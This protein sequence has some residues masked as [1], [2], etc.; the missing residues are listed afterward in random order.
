MPKNKKT[1]KTSSNK[2]LST[3]QKKSLKKEETIVK[4][5]ITEN[6]ESEKKFKRTKLTQKANLYFNVNVFRSWLIKYYKQNEFYIPSPKVKKGEEAPKKS[7]NIIP[8]L[9]G[10]HIALA[11]VSQVLCDHILKKSISQL[12]PE[13]SGLYNICRA[14]I[15]LAVQLN[16]DLKHLFIRAMEFYD[17]NMLYTDQFCLSYSQVMKYIE[18]TMG[19]NVIMLDTKAYNLLA[20]LLLK[21]NM[22]LS[23]TIYHILITSKKRSLGFNTIT[24]AINILCTG[25]LKHDLLLKLQ[26]TQKLFINL[27]NDDSLN[28]E[29]SKDADNDNNNNNDDNDDDD[30]DNSEIDDEI[31]NDNDSDDDNDDNDDD[32]DDNDNDNDDDDDDDGYV[33][34]VDN[35]EEEEEESVVVTKSKKSKKK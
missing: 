15:A 1:K 6:L 27:K 19:K 2:N 3:K 7:S 22:E 9:N 10:V 29:N 18:E 11:A 14:P 34:D 13:P 26:D 12:D 31:D 23:S 5:S 17:W 21:F 4:D 25:S 33:E 35:E 8:K 16:S 20:Y 24:G 28:P 30:D 32:N